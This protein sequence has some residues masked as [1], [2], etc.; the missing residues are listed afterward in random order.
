[1]V[2]PVHPA[3]SLEDF[4]SEKQNVVFLKK[5]FLGFFICDLETS[6]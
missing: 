3:N 4:I 5:S 2:S 6:H 1:M